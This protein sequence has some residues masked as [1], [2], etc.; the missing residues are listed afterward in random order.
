LQPE[1]AREQ[2]PQKGRQHRRHAARQSQWPPTL[3]ACGL[4]EAPDLVGLRQGVESFK[5]F[6]RA[7]QF[8]PLRRDGVQRA[9][10]CGHGSE[11]GG[12]LQQSGLGFGQVRAHGLERLTRFQVGQSFL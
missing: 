9:L 8:H 10:G 12:H 3:S 6:G 7:D 5:R 4:P 2:S 1:R 11:R